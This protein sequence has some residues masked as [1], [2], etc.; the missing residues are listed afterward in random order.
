MRWTRSLSTIVSSRVRE[1]NSFSG[2]TDIAFGVF[3]VSGE[4]CTEHIELLIEV[5]CDG[6]DVTGFGGELDE[7]VV[8]FDVILLLSVA[9][10]MLESI[11]LKS[12]EF[13]KD[14]YA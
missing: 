4:L 11:S 10:D 1:V 2:D 6:C 5:E 7:W 14:G 9:F 12:Y 3:G 8:V 13:D